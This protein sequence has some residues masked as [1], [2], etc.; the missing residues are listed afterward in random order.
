MFTKSFSLFYQFNLNATQVY[1]LIKKYK[2][3]ITAQLTQISPNLK[4]CNSQKEQIVGLYQKDFD[5][6]LCMHAFRISF[7][8]HTPK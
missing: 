3:L 6:M 8:P 1:S 5:S 2:K 7:S 4:F